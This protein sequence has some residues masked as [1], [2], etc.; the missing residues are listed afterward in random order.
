MKRILA[1]SLFTMLGLASRAQQ[2]VPVWV[3]TLGG[4]QWDMANAISLTPEGDVFVAGSFTDSIVIGQS[5]YYSNGLSDVFAAKY[6]ADGELLNSFA[7]GGPSD[8]FAMLANCDNL[9]ILVTKHYG[10]LQLQGQSIDSLAAVNYLVGWF[11][12]DGALLHSQALASNGSLELTGIETDKSGNVY[13]TGWFTQDLLMGGETHTAEPGEN[14]FLAAFKKNG[15]EK[16]LQKW[17]RPRTGRYMA[18]TLDG[19]G[20]LH[21]AGITSEAGDTIDGAP[22]LYYNRLFVT[23]FGGGKDRSGETVLIK[24]LELE[25]VAACELDGRLFVA[26]KFKHYCLLGAD[27]I[28][29]MGQND[30]LMASCNLQGG[31]PTFWTLSGYGNDMP[32]GLSVTNDQ[33]VLTGTFADTLWMDGSHL[34]AGK[35]LGSDLFLIAYNAG[36]NSPLTALALGEAHN[37]FPCAVT[38]SEEGVF[39]LG[40]FRNALYVNGDTLKTNGGYDVFVARYENCGAK[41]ALKIKAKAQKTTQGI[42]TYQLSAADG[43]NN[44]QWNNGLGYGPTAT[45]QLGDSFVVEA[46]DEYGCA[47][48]GHIDLGTEKSASLLAALEE[49]DGFESAFKA[50]PTVTSGKVHWQAGDGFPADGATL[51]IS[52]ASGQSVLTRHYD[53]STQP[54]AVNTLDLGHL[55]RGIYLLELT[56][57]GYNKNF[58]VVLK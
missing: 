13:L 17:A 49:D 29:S 47:C 43:Y 38:A 39:V 28:K 32:L 46:T 35:P 2:M 10:P 1:F 30:I 53:G 15:K 40:Q 27:T 5:T 9:L 23:S 8:D 24:G 6:S 16:N 19:N 11:G 14:A 45:A 44:Y 21:V 31:D 56:G 4:P 12:S 42:P 36:G 54:N 34:L 18:P 52:N 57:T 26:S 3:N 22:G 25:P 48:Y 58:K 7:F 51:R 37:D 33:L 41:Q 55:A 50:Y 20:D